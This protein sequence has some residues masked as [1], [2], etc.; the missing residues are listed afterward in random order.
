MYINQLTDHYQMASG[1]LLS[2]KDDINQIT[3]FQLEDCGCL[4]LI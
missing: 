2:R 1:Y 4:T 3:V